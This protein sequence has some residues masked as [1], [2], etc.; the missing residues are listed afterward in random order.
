MTLAPH[1]PHFRDADP[2]R[3]K[4][5]LRQLHACA[6]QRGI[7]HAD[8]AAVVGC[9]D[10]LKLATEQQLVA[11]IR[12]LGGRVRQSRDREGAVSSPW[13]GYRFPTLLTGAT[14]AQ[15]RRVLW[16]AGRLGMDRATLAGFLHAHCGIPD[17]AAAE[18]DEYCLRSALDQLQARIRKGDTTARK[19]ARRAPVPQSPNPL[20][21][22][23]SNTE[24][25]HEPD[26]DCPL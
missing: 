12:T 17:L 8:L 1:N 23:A 20:I 11:A 6:K 26:D 9:T 5:L 19:D 10:S 7:P 3:Y 13:Y 25:A 16:L 2:Q 4:S 21:P 22:A 24:V 15:R 18:V 14:R